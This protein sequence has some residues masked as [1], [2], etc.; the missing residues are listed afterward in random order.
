MKKFLSA[1]LLFFFCV[2]IGC[3][4]QP[5]YNAEK[6]PISP[7]PSATDKE[8]SEAIWSAGRQEGWQIYQIRPGE[9]KGTKDI[10]VHSMTVKILY[11]RSSFSIY[12]VSSENLKEDDGEIH[13]N[14]NIWVKRLEKQIQEEISF[15][16]PNL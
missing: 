10:R 4:T 1:T 7:R 15:R 14:Y 8:I 11:D 3:K 5:I 2:L 9:M 6:I 16:L 12:Y 13:K